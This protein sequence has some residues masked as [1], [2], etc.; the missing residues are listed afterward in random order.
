MTKNHVRIGLVQMRCQKDPQANLQKALDQIKIAA[1][2]GASIV[3]LQELFN[4]LYFCQ[5]QKTEHFDLA[6]TIPGPATDALCDIAETS[7]SAAAGT[8]SNKVSA[9]ESWPLPSRS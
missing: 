8:A 3:C 5:G 4:T 6:Q 1:R 9:A 7:S 2:K